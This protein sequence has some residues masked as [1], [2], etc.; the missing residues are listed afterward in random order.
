MTKSNPY[1]KLEEAWERR[2]YGVNLEYPIFH[3]DPMISTS[4]RNEVRIPDEIDD[5]KRRITSMNSIE[6]ILKTC[7]EYF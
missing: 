5:L 6:E 1:R 2:E 4:E 3:Y 7:G